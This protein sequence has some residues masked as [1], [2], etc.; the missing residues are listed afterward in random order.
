MKLF[1]LWHEFSPTYNKPSKIQIYTLLFLSAFCLTQLGNSN[2][3]IS[4][5][6]SV[7]S[8]AIYLPHIAN[9]ATSS[10]DGLNL[11]LEQPT[12]QSSNGFNTESSFAVDGSTNG[13][14]GDGS[15][16]VTDVETEPWW[17]VDL[18]DVYDLDQVEVWA[19]TDCCTEELKDL[20]VFASEQNMGTR[21]IADLQADSAVWSLYEETGGIDKLT[22]QTPTNARYVRIQL[23]GER[24]LA[25]AEVR[26]FGEPILKENPVIQVARESESARSIEGSNEPA[27]YVVTRYGSDE[28]STV[29]F[30]INVDVQSDVDEISAD[31]AANNIEPTSDF[32][33]KSNTSFC[34]IPGVAADE[35]PANGVASYNDYVI[36]DE[37]GQQLNGSITFQQGQSTKKII[38]EAIE[39]NEVEVPEVISIELV[40]N[41][42]YDINYTNEIEVYVTEGNAEI[43]DNSR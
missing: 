34:R 28:Q 10:I 4:F 32:F 17:Q 22:F 35:F 25:L 40:P 18:G 26:V 9:R 31:F 1:L 33:F 6:Q 27:V 7:G 16:A 20:Y 15:V 21:S 30:Q 12:N 13:D 36:K 43:G 19:R 24:S 5:A 37:S 39:D 29:P 2:S 42:G 3:K 23:Q 14:F 41:Q 11:A 38:V 8:E